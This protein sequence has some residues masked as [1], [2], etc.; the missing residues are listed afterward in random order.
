MPSWPSA[1]VCYSIACTSFDH[2]PLR[3]ELSIGVPKLHY[4]KD[5][6]YRYSILNKIS[7]TLPL[8]AQTLPMTCVH[9]SVW[10]PLIRW[11]PYEGKVLCLQLD[12]QHKMS[13][14]SGPEAIVANGICLFETGIINSVQTLWPWPPAIDLSPRTIRTRHF[15]CHPN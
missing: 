15:R 9:D 12:N 11:L 6:R 8:I 3:C 14:W 5:G 2:E 7:I 13:G 4:L 10:L 1:Y